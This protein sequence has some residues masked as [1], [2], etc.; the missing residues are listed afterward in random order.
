MVLVHCPMKVLY[1]AVFVRPCS[2]SHPQAHPSYFGVVGCRP[3]ALQAVGFECLSSPGT[4]SILWCGLVPPTCIASSGVRASTRGNVQISV[5][6]RGVWL[7]LC[8]WHRGCSY[9]WYE[10]H[11]EAH[12]HS[13]PLIEKGRRW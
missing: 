3:L 6:V 10:Q 11:F 4:P 7:R 12:S 1:R 2:I 13:F 5:E 9:V 8:P